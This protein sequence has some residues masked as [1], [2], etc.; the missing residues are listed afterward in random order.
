[1]TR[2][3][4][5]I[6]KDSPFKQRIE[7]RIQTST[8]SSTGILLNEEVT[9]TRKRQFL[10]MP[11]VR[12]YQDKDLLRDL[13]PYAWYILGYIS[14]NI[15]WNQ[16]KMKISR[17]KLKMTKDMFKRTMLELLGKEILANTGVR[18]WYWINVGLVIM[19]SINKHENYDT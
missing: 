10:P 15:T 7:K 9:I 6:H 3:A 11:W 16:E 14:L 1:M 2:N 13:T 12:L 19:G 4:L 18:E 5:I 8:D 17:T